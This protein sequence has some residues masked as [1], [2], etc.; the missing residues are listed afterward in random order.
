MKDQQN[1]LVSVLKHLASTRPEIVDA[2]F[3]PAASGADTPQFATSRRRFLDPQPLPPRHTRS[4]PA[5][6][7]PDTT[8]AVPAFD[9]GHDIA[10]DFLHLAWTARSL[11]LDINK[12]LAVIDDTCGTGP[13][14]VELPPFRYDIPP[15]PRPEWM[16]EFQLGFLVRLCSVTSKDQA[17]ANVVAKAIDKVATQVD[18]T[19]RQLSG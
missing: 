14:P 12:S 10:N 3:S 11:G 15:I 13:R 7:A 9:T 2:L 17:I 5:I 6:P 1:P 8:T 4:A 18:L 16:L 19:L